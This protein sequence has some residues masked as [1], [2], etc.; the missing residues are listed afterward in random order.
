MITLFS[1]F[2]G[3]NNGRREETIVASLT[4]YQGMLVDEENGRKRALVDDASSPTPNGISVPRLVATSG[5]EDNIESER[6]L[7]RSRGEFLAQSVVHFEGEVAQFETYQDFEPRAPACSPFQLLPEDIVANCLSFLG[8]VDDRFAVQC[9]SKQFQRISNTEPLLSNIAV[10]GDKQTGRHGII[11]DEDSAETASKLLTPYADAG[12][13]EAIYM[14]GIIL[15]YCRQDVKQ[16][17][18]LLQQAASGGFVRASYA[19]GLALRDTEPETASKY[20]KAAADAEYIPALQEL[21]SPR[22]M[23]ELHG[24]P[25]ADELRLHLDPLCL[26]R[27]LTRH[28]TVTARLRDLNTSH[29]W[30]PLCGRWAFKIIVPTHRE[31]H[32][33]FG[34]DPLLP[35]RSGGYVFP[36]HFASYD[37]QSDPNVKKEAGDLRVSRMKMC[38]R[39]CRAKYCSKLCQVYD[40]RSNRHKMECQFL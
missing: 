5:Q 24:E 6:P 11:K 30:N 4:A 2:F 39:C 26:N 28:Y 1:M 35:A 3:R 25:K 34:V 9:T 33:H 38:S 36:S 29:C 23:K 7:K 13:L 12:N 40:W 32:D 37:G 27:L 15:S 10:G 16:G 14:L 21:L 8:G 18:C 19:L 31:P 17:I 20:M 22:R